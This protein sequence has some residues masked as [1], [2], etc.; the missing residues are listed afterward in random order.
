MSW[1]EK[2]RG[3]RFRTPRGAVE[4]LDEGHGAVGVSGQDIDL[5]ARNRV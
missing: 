5:E 4:E 1:G 2:K 3:A